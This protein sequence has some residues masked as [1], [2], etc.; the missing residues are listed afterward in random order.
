MTY[1]NLMLAWDMMAGLDGLKLKSNSVICPLRPLT[2]YSATKLKP[3]KTPT[4]IL[5][6]L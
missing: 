5:K 3:R 6:A 4:D 1:I 2:G